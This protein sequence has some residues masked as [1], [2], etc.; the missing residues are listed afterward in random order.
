MATR[1][2][3]TQARPPAWPT[4]STPS[5]RQRRQASSRAAA[6]PAKLVGISA[7]ISS[8]SPRRSGRRRTASQAGLIRSPPKGAKPVV[9]SFIVVTSR[10][11][12][13]LFWG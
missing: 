6:Q 8:A 10:Q 11:T 2:T 9:K 7:L 5:G 3:V 13:A 4:H 1:S 12:A